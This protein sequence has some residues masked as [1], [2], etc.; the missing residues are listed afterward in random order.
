M[1]F[2]VS[3]VTAVWSTGL[4][5]A[6]AHPADVLAVAEPIVAAAPQAVSARVER[7]PRLPQ[8]LNL[9]DWRET[10][11]RYYRLAFDPRAEG[12]GLPAVTL[13][14]DGK[15]FGFDS[16]LTPDRKRDARGE[17]HACVLGVVGA[18]LVGLDMTALHGN[19][20]VTPTIEWFDAQA[21]IWSNRPGSG[22][23]IGHVVYEYWPLV[24]GT[25]MADA[26]PE[27][28]EFRD[29]LVRQAD[30]LVEMAKNMGFP[31]RLDLDQHYVR[32]E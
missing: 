31:G 14:A 29:A 10:S 4:C 18:I 8:P 13:S 15:H 30:V 9:I 21:G 3:I 23:A 11:R 27:R 2:S 28:A 32:K 17:A 25:L 26:F 5:L 19:D 7:M 22:R 20:W 24:I 1:R 6:A 12:P 16:Y